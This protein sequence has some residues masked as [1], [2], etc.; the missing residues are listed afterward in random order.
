MDVTFAVDDAHNIKICKTLGISLF[1]QKI[2]AQYRQ[3]LG[4]LMQLYE[5]KKEQSESVEWKAWIEGGGCLIPSN[6][7]LVGLG[8]K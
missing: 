6:V 5:M 3:I 2:Q 7:L 8:K 4:E 1:K